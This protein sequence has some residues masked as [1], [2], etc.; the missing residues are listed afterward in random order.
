MLYMLHH[1]LHGK[2]AFRAD[3]DR[4]AVEWTAVAV[5]VH[6]WANARTRGGDENDSR[7][8]EAR[9]TWIH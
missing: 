5:T 6:Y 8:G 7:A 3:V 1:R 4:R 2:P 9:E